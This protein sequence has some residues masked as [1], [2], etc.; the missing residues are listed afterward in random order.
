MSSI[1]RLIQVSRASLAMNDR[2]LRVAA[3]TASSRIQGFRREPDIADGFGRDSGR[4]V[5]VGV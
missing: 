5:Q 2:V 3:P 1:S 4:L